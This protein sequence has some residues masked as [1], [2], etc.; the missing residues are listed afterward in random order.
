MNIIRETN[1]LNIDADKAVNLIRVTFKLN[2]WL[3]SETSS[4]EKS[5]SCPLEIICTEAL[6][7][8]VSAK[9]KNIPKRGINNKISKI[10]VCN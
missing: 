4:D 1:R 10:I 9:I 3:W 5:F 2:N 6:A 7:L 8:D